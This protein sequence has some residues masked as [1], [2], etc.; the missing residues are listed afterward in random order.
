MG[1][2]GD[3][4]YWD[5]KFLTL[6][7]EKVWLFNLAFKKRGKNFSIGKGLWGLPPFFLEGVKGGEYIS[8]GGHCHY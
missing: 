1:G 5:V 8:R 7:V 2:I 3:G 6:G 4:E